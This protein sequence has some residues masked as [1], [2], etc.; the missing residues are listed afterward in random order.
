MVDWINHFTVDVIGDLAVGESFD[1]LRNSKYHPW[2]KPLFRF[3]QG[4]VFAGAARFYPAVEWLFRMSL[5]NSVMELQRKHTEFVNERIHCRLSLNTDRPDFLIPFMKDN[6][7]YE[8]M[9]LGEIESPF[10]II[11]VAG[12]ETTA[13]SLC[14]TLNHLVKPE[15]KGAFE[16]L[17]CEIRGTF[18]REQD[19]TIEATKHLTYL[20]AVINEGLRVCNPV[21]GGLPR[22]VP[23]GG[24]TYAG[25][26]VPENVY[27]LN[28]EHDILQSNTLNVSRLL[29][30]YDRTSSTILTLSSLPQTRSSLNAGCQRINVQRSLPQIASRPATPLAWVQRV[31][32][33]EILHGPRCGSF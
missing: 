8:N 3:L 20:E 15:N 4:M 19:I 2:V 17:V 33:A 31:A 26:F 28:L 7:K 12:S 9:S 14:G 32:L 23:K 13:T 27:W 29:S 11:L 1:C 18:V 25:H 24:D 30:P 21:P 22:V 6:A 5:P 10:A 16:K